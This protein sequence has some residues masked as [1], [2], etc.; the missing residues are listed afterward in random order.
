MSEHQGDRLRRRRR[1]GTGRVFPA[2]SAGLPQG[3]LGA[4][5]GAVQPRPGSVPV[6]LPGRWQSLPLTGPTRG[7]PPVPSGQ[8]PRA[9]WCPAGSAGCLPPPW[10]GCAAAASRSSSPGG[11]PGGLAGCAAG[12]SRSPGT[13]AGCLAARAWRRPTSAAGARTVSQLMPAT[14]SGRDAIPGP[15]P[16][17]RSAPHSRAADGAA[18]GHPRSW[19]D[20]RCLLRAAV[21]PHR[22]SESLSGFFRIIPV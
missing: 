1:E 13:P 3:V 17:D 8:A 20:W 16:D 11:V 7:V 18:P 19:R 2:R 5:D 10:P 12:I 15:A 6:A 14:G 22:T 9:G 4:G 21:S